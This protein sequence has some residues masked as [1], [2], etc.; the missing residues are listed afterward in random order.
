MT[1][2]MKSSAPTKKT[3]G[4]VTTRSIWIHTFR[5]KSLRSVI[6]ERSEAHST[7]LHRLNG[8]Y[9]G[10]EEGCFTGSEV[11]ERSTRVSTEVHLLHPSVL[12]AMFDD[13]QGD[14]WL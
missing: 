5:K 1:N 11:E 3:D 12:G 4:A 9:R 10:E 14:D 8:I 2:Q 7:F 6:E 13:L